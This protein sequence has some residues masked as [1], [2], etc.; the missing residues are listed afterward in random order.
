[1]NCLIYCS[2]QKRRW[3]LKISVLKNRTLHLLRVVTERSWEH[4]EGCLAFCCGTT[5][6]REEGIYS[7]ITIHNTHFALL[8]LHHNFYSALSALF[9]FI[10]SL[11]FS[12]FIFQQ[13]HFW[14]HKLLRKLSPI[15]LWLM[16]NKKLLPDIHEMRTF[17]IKELWQDKNP[18]LRR[19][20]WIP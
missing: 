1:M 20:H 8:T 14:I 2:S 12:V 11:Y 6:S 13:Q 10:Q 19:Q 3:S 5:I 7:Y 16:L 15:F 9:F 18:Y 4:W 17:S